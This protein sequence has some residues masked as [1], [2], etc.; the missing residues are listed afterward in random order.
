M[1]TERP[2]QKVTRFSKSTVDSHAFSPQTHTLAN[3]RQ[4]TVVRAEFTQ[5]TRI[6]PMELRRSYSEVKTDAI[7]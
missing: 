1:A 2:A 4:G 7:N 5:S 6:E 3:F